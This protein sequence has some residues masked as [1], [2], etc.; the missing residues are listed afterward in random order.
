MRPSEIMTSRDWPRR[1][2]LSLSVSS[3]AV[4]LAC[5][6]CLSAPRPPLDV[7]TTEIPS[8][9]ARPNLPKPNPLE[10]EPYHWNVLAPGYWR[11][12]DAVYFCLTP[13]DYESAARNQAEILR[14]IRE[15]MWQ[16]DY[17]RKGESDGTGMGR[18]NEGT[19]QR[20]GGK[21]SREDR[22]ADDDQSRR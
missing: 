6:G 15:T 22:D 16:L 18:S 21:S 14:F 20:R 17:Y 2:L 1:S 9:P 12:P 8:P 10:M 13:P 19:D 3:I 5:S 4:L 11:D 7:T